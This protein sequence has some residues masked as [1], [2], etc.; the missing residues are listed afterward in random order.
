MKHHDRAMARWV[1][2]IL[3]VAGVGSG[4]K[5]D[6]QQE[7]IRDVIS[8]DN[9]RPLAEVV[10]AL[11]QRYGV[12]IT[13]EDP[14][15]NHASQRVD[16]SQLVRRDRGLA[17][18][19]TFVPSGGRFSFEYSV[20]PGLGPEQF[21]GVLTR[22]L[23]QYRSTD[24]AHSFRL[25]KTDAIYH[26]VPMGRRGE[27][28]GDEDYE[29]ILSSDVPLVRREGP[30]SAL[31]ALTHL[32]NMVQQ[33]AGVSVEIATVPVNLLNRTEVSDPPAH[34]PARSELLRILRS[35]GEQLSWRLLYDPNGNGKF[36]LNI[37]SVPKWRAVVP[38]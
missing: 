36:Y 5:A 6:A 29:A 20:K 24:Y 2:V 37:H 10:K 13:Y 16:V 9:A 11:E 25:Q 3:V 38:R 22:L 17:G 4:V 12:V 18:V 35:T 21:G 30:H 32:V 27:S 23:Q 28:G 19:R 26:I 7:S 15:Y 14:P 8:V 31:E 1:L 33:T 34:S